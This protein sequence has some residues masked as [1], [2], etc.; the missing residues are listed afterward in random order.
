[1]YCDN[2]ETPVPKLSAARDD[3][4]DTSL[5]TPVMWESFSTSF[6]S[7]TLIVVMLL[8]FHSP[9]TTKGGCVVK[10]VTLSS[11]MDTTVVLNRRGP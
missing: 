4:A 7:V 6:A 5:H 1:M 2:R 8:C 9:T 10:D 11:G 3:G